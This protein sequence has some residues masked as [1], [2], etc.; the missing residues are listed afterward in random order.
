[1]GHVEETDELCCLHGDKVGFL[2]STICLIKETMQTKNYQAYCS[3]QMSIMPKFDP[4]AYSTEH[5]SVEKGLI[6]HQNMRANTESVKCTLIMNIFERMLEFG[7]KNMHQLIQEILWPSNLLVTASVSIDS[8]YDSVGINFTFVKKYGEDGHLV[9]DYLPAWLYHC[10]SDEILKYLSPD[11]QRAVFK[12]KWDE[13]KGIPVSITELLAQKCLVEGQN[14]WADENAL[15]E[16]LD[17]FHFKCP[18]KAYKEY[19]IDLEKCSLESFKCG[20]KGKKAGNA[21]GSGQENQPPMTIAMPMYNPPLAED[22]ITMCNS[23]V[24]TRMTNM[25]HLVQDLCGNMDQIKNDL[26]SLLQVLCNPSSFALASDA[27]RFTQP[28]EVQEN[29]KDQ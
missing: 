17:N 28:A 23:T 25:E 14:K 13:E 11:A 4:K 7:N 3:I 1:M 2:D 21:N 26:Q 20:E 22:K 15:A 16:S 5:S 9:V 10:H 27:D 18:G 8:M 12:M 19:L 6:H 29:A 24:D